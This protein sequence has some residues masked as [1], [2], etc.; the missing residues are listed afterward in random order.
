MFTPQSTHISKLANQIPKSIDRLDANFSDKELFSLAENCVSFIENELP[1]QY[2]KLNFK[3]ERDTIN[4]LV[5]KCLNIIFKANYTLKIDTYEDT[6][7]NKAYF[8]YD[9]HFEPNNKFI[10][11]S[12]ISQFKETP[13]RIGFAKLIQHFGGFFND[14]TSVIDGGNILWDFEAFDGILEYS[15]E[16]IESEIDKKIFKKELRSLKGKLNRLNKKIYKYA[17]MDY[18]IFL[19]YRPRSKKNKEIKALIL[20]L[21]GID[22]SCVL[23]FHE[24]SD[25][26]NDGLQ[27]FF[28]FYGLTCKDPIIEDQI[29]AKGALADSHGFC[30]PAAYILYEEG[31]FKNKTTD[32][33]IQQFQSLNKTINNLEDTFKNY[34]LL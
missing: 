30:C 18:S 9:T 34:G 26:Q 2:K 22:L 19:S 12:C 10:N 1:Q 8:L 13:L 21:L 33:D 28:E 7:K 31:I 23:S 25:F 11:A 3:R 17:S 6:E 29:E 32:F 20:K 5:T 14:Y 4:T 15:Y 27:H 16:G 24:D